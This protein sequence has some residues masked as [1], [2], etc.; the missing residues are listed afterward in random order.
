MSC[1]GYNPVRVY[2]DKDQAT[3]VK[4]DPDPAWCA[5]EKGPDCLRWT[6]KDLPPQVRSV[7]IEWKTTGVGKPMF[8]GH[9]HAGTTVGSHL[10]DIITSGNLK[11]KGRFYYSVYCY[12]KDGKLVAS[13]DPGVDNDPNPPS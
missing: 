1:K 5:W 4:C 12:D 3:V 2:I 11:E 10:P 13:A 7:V 6:F 8:R 9:G